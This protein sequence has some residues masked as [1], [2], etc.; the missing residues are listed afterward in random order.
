[1]LLVAHE[2]DRAVEPALAQAPSRGETGE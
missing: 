2:R 1:M